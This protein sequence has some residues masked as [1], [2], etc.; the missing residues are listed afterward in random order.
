MIIQTNN[1]DFLLNVILG[2]NATDLFAPSSVLFYDAGSN[3]QDGNNLD[4]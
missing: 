1:F 4:H 3:G 2:D